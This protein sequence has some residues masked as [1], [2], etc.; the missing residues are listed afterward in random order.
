MNSVVKPIFNESFAE[1]R[2]GSREQCKDPLEKHKSH[3]NV[4]LKKKKKT[5]ADADA[6]ADTKR[7]FGH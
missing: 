1:K 3:I 4:L 2:G 6:D 5:D 7:V